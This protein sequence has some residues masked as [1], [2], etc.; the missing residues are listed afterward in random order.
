MPDHYKCF[1][2]RINK[3]MKTSVEK[4]HNNMY[5]VL[6]DAGKQ[7]ASVCGRRADRIAERIAELYG[8]GAVCNEWDL[9]R[10]ILDG[11]KG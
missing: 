4:L 8:S 11:N 2:P 7:I 9:A 3:G 1:A 6:D 10:R 5:R